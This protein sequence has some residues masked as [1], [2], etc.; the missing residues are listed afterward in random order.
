MSSSKYF[1]NPSHCHSLYVTCTESSY[2][3]DV[4]YCVSFSLALK[5]MPSLTPS[6]A[7]ACYITPSRSVTSHSHRGSQCRPETR[8]TASDDNR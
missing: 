7:V 5:N 1:T 2:F 4:R 8:S 6:V 3:S